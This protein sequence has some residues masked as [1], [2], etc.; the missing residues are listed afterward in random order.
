MRG[1]RTCIPPP[2]RSQQTWRPDAPAWART[3][4][5]ERVRRGL[6][7][8]DLAAQLGCRPPTIRALETG[9]IRHPQVAARWAEHL[10]HTLVAVPIPREES[11]PP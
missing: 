8:A 3:L 11:A 10:G 1:A 4:H 7:Q 5:E 6:T 2:V 9:H